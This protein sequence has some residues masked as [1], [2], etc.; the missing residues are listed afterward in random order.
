[1]EEIMEIYKRNKGKH[2]LFE[3][4][5]IVDYYDGPIAAIVKLKNFEKWFVCSTVYFDPGNDLRILS[6]LELNDLWMNENK[7]LIYEAKMKNIDSYKKMKSKF[8]SFYKIYSGKVYLFK[9]N[10]LL[11]SDYEIVEIPV[12]DLMYFNDIEAVLNQPKK[13]KLKWINFFK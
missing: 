4:Y 2:K 7:L 1:M 5:I 12:S 6:L 10:W 11:S 9:S 8:R 3:D 13:S